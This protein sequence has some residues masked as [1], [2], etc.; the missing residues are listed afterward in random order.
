[1]QSPKNF[2]EKTLI[3]GQK[4]NTPQ[5]HNIKIPKQENRDYVV[6]YWITKQINFL[7]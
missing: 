3:I 4:K 7:E 6:S 2:N 5:T 1:M